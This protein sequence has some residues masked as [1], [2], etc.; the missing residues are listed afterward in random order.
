VSRDP[1]TAVVG[2]LFD[3]DGTLIDFDLTW[4]PAVHAMI[5]TL[6][7][8]G[9]GRRAPLLRRGQALPNDL[10]AGRRFDR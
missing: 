1:S 2:V 8:A 9:A 6:A 4:G 5:H 3:K 10:T 7:G